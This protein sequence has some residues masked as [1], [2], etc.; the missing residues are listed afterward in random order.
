MKGL[1][2]IHYNKKWIC[3]D[4]CCLVQK[5]GDDEVSKICGRA[6]SSHGRVF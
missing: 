5:I 6:S 1:A 3:M 4:E 2:R